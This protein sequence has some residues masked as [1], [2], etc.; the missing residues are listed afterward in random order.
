[1]K[2]VS[3][4]LWN[5]S[6]F[7][8]L[9]EY[10]G[11]L[12]RSSWATWVDEIHFMYTE[13][14]TEITSIFWTKNW[15]KRISWLQGSNTL[16]WVLLLKRKTFTVTDKLIPNQD[17]NFF[18]HITVLCCVSAAL[19]FE[20]NQQTFRDCRLPLRCRWGRRSSGMLRSVSGSSVPTFRENLSVQYSRIKKS[21]KKTFFEF[22]TLA[23]GT[24]R[25]SRNVGT[26]LPLNAA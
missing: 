1:M 13:P 11:R 20:P 9:C 18:C 3:E 6:C 21:K 17:T 2:L 23:D 15:Q 22:L 14:L 19:N 16:S 8:D 12:L 10:P 24:H 4:A 5:L 7:E 25:L 26:E